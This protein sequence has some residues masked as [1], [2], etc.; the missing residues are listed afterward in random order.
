VPPGSSSAISLQE[1]DAD[2][3]PTQNCPPCAPLFIGQAFDQGGHPDSA[4]KYRTDYVEMSGTDR[5]FI[6]RY[7]LANALFRLGELYESANDKAATEY[8]GRFV[9]LWA[10]ADPELQ[11]RV[12]EARARIERLNR[13]RQ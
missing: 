3:L 7:H 6:D 11:P 9:D 10:Q 5:Q 4:R 1:T 12:V 2:G 13:P 8:Y